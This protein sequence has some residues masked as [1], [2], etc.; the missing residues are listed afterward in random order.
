VNSD[1]YG[2]GWLVTVRPAD[3]AATSG[4]LDASAYQQT[5]DAAG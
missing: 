4:L 3:E 2:D 1:P 5:V